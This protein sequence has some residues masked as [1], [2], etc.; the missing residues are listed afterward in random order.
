MSKWTD[1]V[2]KHYVDMKKTMKYVKLGD[3]MK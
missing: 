2:K 3:A 1:F